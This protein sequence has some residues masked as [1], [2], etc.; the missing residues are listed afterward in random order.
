MA[1]KRHWHIKRQR[2]DWRQFSPDKQLVN[3]RWR[4]QFVERQHRFEKLQ[5]WEGGAMVKNE[6]Q[7]PASADEEGKSRMDNNQGNIQ[8]QQQ[9]GPQ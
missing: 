6:T 3:G 2:H 5:G 7:K 9:Q 1:N 4:Y 8:Q